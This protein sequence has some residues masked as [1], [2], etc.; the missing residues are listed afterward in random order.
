MVYKIL[1]VGKKDRTHW[2]NVVSEALSGTCEV[3]GI[4][5]ELIVQ[6]MRQTHYDLIIIDELNVTDVVK[7][8][9]LA[10]KITPDVKVIVATDSTTWRRARQAFLAGASDYIYKTL[11]ERKIY[12]QIIPV[13]ESDPSKELN[14]RYKNKQR[15]AKIVN[16]TNV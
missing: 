3:Q 8:T 15:N 10:I 4:D 6:A 14:Y 9:H 5:E 11:D 12:K 2:Y 13:L 16:N 1:L 7:L